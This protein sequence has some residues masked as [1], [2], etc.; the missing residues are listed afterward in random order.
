[1]EEELSQKHEPGPGPGGNSIQEPEPG[2]NSVQEPEPGD[3][4]AREPDPEQYADLADVIESCL[5][6]PPKDWSQYP[7][8]SLAW[9]GDTVY[10]L[11]VRSVLLRRGMT[12]P[13]RLH[14]KA[15]LIVN[16]RAQAALMGRIRS[17]LTPEEQAVCRRGHNAR[18]AHKAKNADMGAYLEATAL[19]C[20]V[21]YLYLTGQYH[22]ILELMKETLE[23]I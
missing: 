23:S 15:A 5:Q 7:P 13:D 12:R 6:L 1:M 9:I 18:P 10:D 8:L 3:N 16:A 20:L 2:D 17:R 19:E 22:R 4:S 11:V 21:G 14:R